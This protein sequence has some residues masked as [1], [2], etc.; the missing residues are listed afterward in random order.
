MERKLA[1]GRLL[2]PEAMKLDAAIRNP[3]DVLY[4][5][6]PLILSLSKDEPVEAWDGRH[7][8]LILRQAQDEVFF[9]INDLAANDPPNLSKSVERPVENLS[10]KCRSNVDAL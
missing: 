3:D 2:L 1:P 8:N 10:R 7:R 6:P 5:F 4:L 9:W